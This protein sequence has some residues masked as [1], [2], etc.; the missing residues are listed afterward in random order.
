MQ[1]RQIVPMVKL[2]K[3]VSCDECEHFPPPEHHTWGNKANFEC[4][5]NIFMRFKMPS[6]PVDEEW[7]FY[8]KGC[9]KFSQKMD[10][11]GFDED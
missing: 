2:L 3:K 10:R 4:L 1:Q 8:Q 6:S 11:C 9:R 5:L 7:G